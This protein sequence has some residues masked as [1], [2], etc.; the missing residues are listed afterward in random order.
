MRTKTLCAAIL[1][2]V[3]FSARAAA[4]MMLVIPAPSTAPVDASFLSAEELIGR[5]EALLSTSVPPQPLPE[6]KKPAKSGMPAQP[7]QYGETRTPLSGIVLMPTAYRGRG[8]NSIGLGLDINAAYFIGRLYGKNSYEWTLDKKNYLDRIGVWL[9]TGD[10]KMLIQTEGRLRPALAVGALGILQ[11]RDSPQPTL[12]QP[13]ASVAI[14]SKNT[15]TY[16]NAYVVLTKR[17]HPNIILNAGYT[18]GDMPKIVYQ[19]SEFLSKEAL[20]LNGIS[21]F[22]VP[23]GMLFG[24]LMWAPKSGSP[25]GIEVLLPQGAPQSPRL[26]N[27]HLGTLLK[28]NF[29]ISYLAF[30]GGWDMLGMFQFRYNYFPR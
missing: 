25:I 6:P 28:M 15:A 14:D 27:L 16:T 26:F 21:N 24:G 5:A 9:L 22:T 3:A 12:T 7:A 20:N 13:G 29:E 17:L 19:L 8:K 4:Q 23:T 2:S 30:K 1:L 18:D 10:A 11:F